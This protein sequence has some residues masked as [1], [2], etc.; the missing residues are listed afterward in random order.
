MINMMRCAFS[1][2]SVLVK[3]VPIIKGQ[4]RNVAL[5]QPRPHQLLETYVS[6]APNTIW[7]NPGAR[8]RAKRVGRGPGSGKGY[9][10][11]AYCIEKLLDEE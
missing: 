6:L 8:R 3:S 9:R 7:D 4:W 1:L 5:A 10:E 11:I 2:A